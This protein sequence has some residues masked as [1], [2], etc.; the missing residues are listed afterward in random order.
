MGVVDCSYLHDVRRAETFPSTAR[1]YESDRGRYGREL[2]VSMVPGGCS[3]VT[4]PAAW[5][6]SFCREA[7]ETS[8]YR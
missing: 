1:I 8:Y 6:T 2:A 5:G 3:G 7:G 4:A